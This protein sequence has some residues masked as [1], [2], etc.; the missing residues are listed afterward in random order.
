[1]R[2]SAS[3]TSSQVP[4]P[5][6]KN[7]IASASRTRNSF[8][9]KK[10]LK[11]TSLGSSAIHGL[12]SCSDGSRM[13]MPNDRSPPAPSWAAPITPLPAPV[14]TIQLTAVMRLPKL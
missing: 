13:L 12:A 2:T 5:P 8:R 10:Y 6:G 11:L 7:A 4:K 9:V 3:N 1:M 14:I